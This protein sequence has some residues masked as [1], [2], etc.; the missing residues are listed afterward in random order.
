MQVQTGLGP[1]PTSVYWRKPHLAQ[2]LVE[3]CGWPKK[4]TS[5]RQLVFNH[6]KMLQA[7][8]DPTVSH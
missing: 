4:S 5:S 1:I 2:H 6:T 8:A 7:A 3:A